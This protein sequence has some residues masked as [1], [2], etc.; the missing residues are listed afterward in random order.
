MRKYINP[1]VFFRTHRSFTFFLIGILS[2][3]CTVRLPVSAIYA[4]DTESNELIHWPE[5]VD[6]NDSHRLRVTAMENIDQMLLF[7]VEVTNKNQDSLYVNPQEWQLD[8]RSSKYISSVDSSSHPLNGP[9]VNNIYQGIA[10]RIKD[11]R[12]GTTALIIVG[13]VAIIVIAI[14]MADIDSGSWQEGS[15]GNGG[16]SNFN[17]FLNVGLNSYRPPHTEHWTT[18]QKITYYRRRGETLK[19]MDM[20]PQFIPKGES[21]LYGFFFPRK[22]SVDWLTLRGLVDDQSYTWEF[23]HESAGMIKIL[24]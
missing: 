11:A 22:E 3:S 4:T 16:G 14:A 2:F 7:E 17:F 24:N 1:L 12:D 9:E 8:Y 18:K 21:R 5:F 19:D 23:K 15:S 6:E 13:I 20:S 10:Q